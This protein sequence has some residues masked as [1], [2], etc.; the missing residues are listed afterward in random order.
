[1]SLCH[2]PFHK[3]NVPLDKIGLSGTFYNCASTSLLSLAFIFSAVPFGIMH[4]LKWGSHVLPT[5]GG[6]YQGLA[7]ICIIVSSL[8]W[9]Q[10]KFET[11]RTNLRL[12]KTALSLQSCNYRDYA[13]EYKTAIDS[14]FNRMFLNLLVLKC[15]HEWRLAIQRSQPAEAAHV[16]SL[17]EVPS[18]FDPFEL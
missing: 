14:R 15:A 11:H 5:G 10:E 17:P 7:F 16:P 4:P 1:V 6:Y 9:W 18:Q 8:A 12:L 3:L 13:A 2:V